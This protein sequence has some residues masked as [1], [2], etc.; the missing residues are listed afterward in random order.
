MVTLTIGGNDTMLFADALVR[1]LFSGLGTAGR[2]SPCADRYGARWTDIVDDVTRP[3]LISSFRSIRDRAP[4][5]EIAVLGY[6]R[7]LPETGGCFAQTGIASGDVP[8]LSALQ[9]QLN[10]AI[11]DAA[12]QAHTTFVDL[13]GATLGHDVC[14]PVGVRWVEPVCW[15]SDPA[16]AHPNATG[17]AVMADLALRALHR[18]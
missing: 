14:Q 11:A 2:G 10:G 7:I 3:A 13:S 9:T 5:A 6:P 8:H 17:Q 4:N 1:C 18:L 12:R 15:G 16:V